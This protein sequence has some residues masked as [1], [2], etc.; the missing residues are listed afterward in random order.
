M[1]QQLIE[2]ILRAVGEDKDYRINVPVF[3]DGCVRVLADLRTKAPE[4]VEQMLGE[5][6][7]EV[8]EVMAKE[9][10]SNGRYNACTEIINSLK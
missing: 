8:Q 2:I 6:R 10:E 3:D 4:I 7:N 1:K 5:I 9:P